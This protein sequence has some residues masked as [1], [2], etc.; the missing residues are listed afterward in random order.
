M[1]KYGRHE[2]PIC[3]DC[4]IM[5]ELMA[6]PPSGRDGMANKKSGE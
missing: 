5:C 1:T 4:G 6:L 3:D 2:G